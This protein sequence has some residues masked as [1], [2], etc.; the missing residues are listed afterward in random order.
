MPGKKAQE[1]V[2]SIVII[3]G[4]IVSLVGAAFFWGKPLIEK[5]TTIAE[6][7]TIEDFV[8]NLNDK[9]TDIA[10]SGSGR[11]E[12]EI[13]MGALK[14]VAYNP[15]NPSQG[16][17]IFLEYPISQ[18]ILMGSTI[19]VKTNNMDEIATFGEAQPRMITMSVKPSGSAYLMNMT[20]HYRELDTATVPKKGF[21]IKL[22][23]FRHRQEHN[24][25]LLWR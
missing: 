18:P 12:I 16:N 7:T 5:R 20:L 22:I 19:P 13:P 24:N 15:E 9:I 2:M 1:Q 14:A 23:R 3:T 10:N 25:S 11:H 21:L 8:V 4:I 6:Y 17:M